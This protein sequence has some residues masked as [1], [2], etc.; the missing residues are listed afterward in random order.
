MTE[1]YFIN[2]YY[3]EA[4]SWHNAA[5]SWLKYHGD[6]SD[7]AF[8][9]IDAMDNVD[10][11]FSMLNVFASEIIERAGITKEYYYFEDYY[12]INEENF[13]L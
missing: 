5:K 2:D 8:K 7:I 4:T 1:I 12:N 9:A 11:I 3:V 13:E 10:D 6:A